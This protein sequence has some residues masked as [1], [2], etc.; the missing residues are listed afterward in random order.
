MFEVNWSCYKFVS[1][2]QRNKHKVIVSETTT[3][4]EDADISTHI[5]GIPFDV[6]NCDRNYVSGEY[7]NI[8]RFMR[9]MIDFYRRL[10]Q[11][12]N[13]PFP[14]NSQKCHACNN[15]CQ[16]S[17]VKSKDGADNHKVAKTSSS[18]KK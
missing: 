3:S 11:E 7:N 16:Q 8:P 14:T 13:D 10:K 4:G 15:H 12:R 5:N 9:I 17:K 2:L 1:H 18:Q 6:S